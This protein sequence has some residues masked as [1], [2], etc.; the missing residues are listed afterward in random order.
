MFLLIV[1][2][3]IIVPICTYNVSKARFDRSSQSTALQR[4]PTVPYLVP[5]VFHA[6]SLAFDGPQKYFATLMYVAQP[7]SWNVLTTGSKEHGKFAPFAVKV[8]L[9]SFVVLRDPEHV[10]KIVEASKQ[11]GPD[12]SGSR[13]HEIAFGSSKAVANLLAGTTPSN[14]KK[15]ATRQ[16]RISLT[17]K[18]LTGTSLANT[19]NTYVNTLSR[20]MN[21]KMFQVGSWTQIEDV[22][23]FFQQVLT[24]CSVEIFF[25]SA[26]FKQYPKLIKDYWQFEDAVEGFVPGMPLLLVSGSY[27]EPRDRLCQNIEKWLKLN[28]SGTEFAKI[29][30]EDPDVDEH[31]GSK[32]FQECDD[33]LAKTPLPLEDRTAEMLD[34]IHCSNANFIPSTIWTLIEILRKPDLAEYLTSIITEYRSPKLGTYDVN[35]IATLPLM[36]SLQ[37]EIS[38][39]RVAQYMAYNNDSSDIVL[40]K[41]SILPKGCTAI[42][43]SQDLALNAEL[44]TSAR[45]RVVEKP[46]EEFWAE[47]FLV[48]GNQN[49]K[50]SSKQRKSKDGIE[51]GQFSMEG[52][53][54]LAPAFGNEHAIGLGREYT[55]AMQTA[56]LAVLLSEFE[57]ELCDPDATD[58]AMPQLREVAFGTVRPKE[59]VTFP[60]PRWVAASYLAEFYYDIVHGGQYF[61][62]IIEMHEKYGPIVRITPHELS[63]NDPFF[64]DKVFSSSAQKRDKDRYQTTQGGLPSTA[65]TTIDHDLHRQRR[66]YVS[67]LF[68]KKAISSLE[69]I[70]QSKVDLLVSKLKQAH[71]KQETLA[72]AFVFA[73]LTTDVVTHFA[74]G[75]S[76]NELSKPGFPL[77]ARVLT[78]L[79]PNLIAYLQFDSYLT[80]L[81]QDALDKNRKAS[82]SE[83]PRTLFDALANP[84]IPVQERTL[85]RMK[86]ES[87]VVLLAG[88]D[89]T[90]RFLMVMTAYLV[91]FPDVLAKLREEMRGLEEKGVEKPSWT[92]LEGLPYLTTIVGIPYLM[93]SH[94]DVFPDPDTFRPERWIEATARGEH[95]EKY[96]VT[97]SKGSRICLGINLAYAELYLTVAALVKNFELELVGSTLEDINSHRDFGLGFNKEYD[98]G[99]DFRVKRVL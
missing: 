35:G 45:P 21:D 49:T 68:S 55:E 27:K 17:Q 8:G 80:Q 7:H 70:I 64:Y 73:A 10:K 66:G 11:Q 50:V 42:A 89:T 15:K 95:L 90:A 9:R 48:P 57:F 3:L 39:L 74:Y 46:L 61:K 31:K 56:T 92:Q 65:I 38:R 59:G 4:P 96:L 54:Q 91:E 26:I 87:A 97:F 1:F 52:L 76:F 62:K 20:N 77:P 84:E 32:F 13:I 16:V 12:V 24:R 18:Y 25:G 22:W 58:A 40:D 78:W 72:G 85:E 43:F 83:K 29:G 79:D 28:H 34:I 69:P 6:F 47:R 93:N 71:A 63:L 67:H 75:E 2:L 94:P 81:S 33:L 60:G 36:K 14:G 82:L 23:S 86:N 37:E 53:E 44:W 99:V 19:T 5:G 51:T 30:E 88:L 98:F 41:R